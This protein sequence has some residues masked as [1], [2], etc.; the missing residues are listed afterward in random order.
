MEGGR[1]AGRSAAEVAIIH[2]SSGELE[3]DRRRLF[4]RFAALGIEARTVPYPRAARPDLA[5]RPCQVSS[6]GAGS[7][8]VSGKE[9]ACQSEGAR[10]SRQPARAIR[11]R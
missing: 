2:A 1:P 7:I 4:E 11:R 5:E 9:V 3:I 6:G 10:L 8:I